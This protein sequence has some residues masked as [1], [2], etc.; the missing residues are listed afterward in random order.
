MDQL[1]TIAIIGT[2]IAT[3]LLGTYR[4]GRMAG[5]SLMGTLVAVA[6]IDLWSD[7]WTTWL[8]ETFTPSNPELAAF[9]LTTTAFVGVVGVVGYGGA[10][11]LPGTG[12]VG[13]LAAP[14]RV[15][16][17]LLGA[18][19]GAL[20]MAYMLRYAQAIWPEGEATRLLATIPAAQALNVWLPW[21]W[22]LLVCGISLSVGLR[23]VFWVWG[24]IA[25]RMDD[26]W[27]TPQQRVAEQD[28]RVLHKIDDALNRRRGF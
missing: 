20:I 15:A 19:N 10:S 14:G 25:G 7:R 8:Y 21:F 4:F 28:R 22:L 26:G 2:I 12:T 16:G 6:L 24:N 23:S 27:D 11:L 13:L 17:A 5:L 9:V 3:A 18:L 1:V